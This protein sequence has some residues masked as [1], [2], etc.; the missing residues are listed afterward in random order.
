M[1]SFGK[2]VVFCMLFLIF[3]V[4]GLS[5]PWKAQD[6][7]RSGDPNYLLERYTTE[8]HLPQNSVSVIE[9]DRNGFFWLA[10]YSGLVR[11]DGRTFKTFT[12][13]DGDSLKFTSYIR[14]VKS[15]R[16]GRLVGYAQETEKR[17]ATYFAIRNG[18]PVLAPASDSESVASHYNSNLQFVFPTIY[19]F[20][21]DSSAKYIIEVAVDGRITVRY[22][23]KNTS[24][25]YH[26]TSRFPP[27]SFFIKND[28][29]YIRRA[30]N[31]LVQIYKD[32]VQVIRITIRGAKDDRKM[33]VADIDILSR[34]QNMLVQHHDD[35]YRA[36]YENRQLVL[37]YLFSEKIED[38]TSAYVDNENDQVLIGTSSSGLYVFKKNSF[39]VLL[40]AEGVKGNN[41]IYNLSLIKN[42]YL[43]GTGSFG[44]DL[45]EKKHFASEYRTNIYSFQIGRQTWINDNDKRQLVVYDTSGIVRRIN[46][47]NDVIRRGLMLKD[48]SVLLIGSKNLHRFSHDHIETLETPGLKD[49]MF[50]FKIV[51]AFL[52]NDST[53]QLVS[54]DNGFVTFPV[55]APENFRHYYSD[56]LVGTQWTRY[57]TV[58]RISW[59]CS[60]ANAIT[61]FTDGK[62]VPLPRDRQNAI[63]YAYSMVN[64][65]LG[66]IW[67]ST[68][69]GLLQAGSRQVTDYVKGKER[70][71]F[72]NKWNHSDGLRVN[73]FN[74]GTVPGY[75]IQDDGTIFLPS[76]MGIVSF[77]PKT[78]RHV[79][80][81]YPV[82]VEQVLADTSVIT[83]DEPV[84]KLKPDF[85][86][87]TIR[88]GNAYY[89]N[90]ENNHLQY[91]ILPFD[92]S[93]TE[94]P[95]NGEIAFQNIGRGAY[96]IEV[97]VNYGVDNSTA[98]VTQIKVEILP[99]WYQTWLAYVFFA[100]LFGLT[101]FLFSQLR[102]YS[103]RK[104]NIQ[105][106]R[107]INQRNADLLSLIDEL[108]TINSDNELIV[109]AMSHD[110]RAPIHMSMLASE[111]LTSNWQSF[112]D[113][114]KKDINVSVYNVLKKLDQFIHDFLSEI[115]FDGNKDEGKSLAVRD[116]IDNTIR[117][118][119]YFH[120]SSNKIQ[121]EVNPS[122]NFLIRERVLEIMIGNII[123]NATKYSRNGIIK[124]TGEIENS[125]L[126][127]QVIDSGVPMT[128]GQISDVLSEPTHSSNQKF[129][130]F[131]I[132]LLIVK[133]FLMKLNGSME[134]T[135]NPTS[136]MCVTV[137]IPNQ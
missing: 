15:T 34:T 116:V 52:I 114:T 55:N 122:V 32:R 5:T 94:L 51:D 11:W 124:I 130:S 78:V 110:V 73:E 126:V 46:V 28:T 33:E 105:L 22:Q 50:R 90:V 109:T 88:I 43:V 85:K 108:K 96:T 30:G 66:N 69:N 89:G 9:K 107:T 14:L 45:A 20:T 134:I 48:G 2:Q 19:R 23:A 103:I 91:R 31:E 131:H 58:N 104:T 76:E 67:I 56:K 63:D 42:R 125:Q 64:D 87:V 25:V 47:V 10:T 12:K 83:A 97:F 21:K 57:D 82:T 17:P 18:R 60:Y 6:L 133:R 7:F 86:K 77:N 4:Q 117:K 98:A 3:S 53:C 68:N 135:P 132:G 112:D 29:L 36:T 65:P 37:Q 44:Y 39:S 72:Y 71:V 111:T 120:G 115:S 38:I 62:F 113:N 8:N 129:K 35:F 75:A 40:S 80:K 121:N 27:K 106:E 92:T 128:E 81:Q 95:A 70:T 24:K 49:K 1:Y 123:E 74:G 54:G 99:K 137:R 102:S 127:V 16:T 101:I 61:A 13:F 79:F 26:F 100:T 118:Y 93:W 41:H 119:G 136:G 59:F 84:I